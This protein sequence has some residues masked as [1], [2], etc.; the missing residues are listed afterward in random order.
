M[1]HSALPLEELNAEVPSVLMISG[2]AVCIGLVD[3]RV[4]AISDVCPHRGSSLGQGLLRDGCVT[5]PAH[6]WRFSLI[7]GRKQ[8]DE[9]VHVQTFATRIVDGMIEVKVPPLAAPQTLREVLLA[10]A[11]GETPSEGVA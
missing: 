3:S 5:C 8:G 4:Y 1:W 10:H 6:L 11:R 2:Q 9:R 7:D